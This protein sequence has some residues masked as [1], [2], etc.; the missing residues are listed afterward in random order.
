[1]TLELSWHVQNCD[2]ILSHIFHV[3][4]TCIF[5]RF[6]LWAYKLLVKFPGSVGVPYCVVWLWLGGGCGIHDVLWLGCQHVAA[7][8]QIHGWRGSVSYCINWNQKISELV[9]GG[10]CMSNEYG[11]VTMIVLASGHQV[12]CIPWVQMGIFNKKISFLCGLKIP[13]Y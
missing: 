6:R 3:K 12:R 2:L 4:A 10:Q 8:A 7:Q 9:T 5:A 11:P 13:D 1:M